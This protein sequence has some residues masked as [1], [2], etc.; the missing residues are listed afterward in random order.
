[1]MRKLGLNFQKTA[2]P[3]RRTAGWVLLLVG[4]ALLAEMGVSYKRLQTDRT[5]MESEIRRSNIRMDAQNEP[6]LVNKYTDK[7]FSE[8]RKIINRLSIPWDMFF[9][10]LESVSDK[11]VAIL[12]IE[13]DTH[14]GLL[15][16]QGEAKNY[17]GVLNLI[18]RLRTTKPFSYVFLLSH[19]TKRDDPQHP[20]SFTLTL[21]W[22]K[23]S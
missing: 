14:T 7:D 12:A 22:V 13:P 2:N 11:T 1:M 16:I 10:G 19:E 23:P 3:P 5:T 8:G 9:S 18:A 17:L 6:P 20:V 15:R 4:L 21:H